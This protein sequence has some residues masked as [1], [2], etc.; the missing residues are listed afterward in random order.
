MT[1]F[2][3][4]ASESVQ[5]TLWQIVDEPTPPLAPVKANTWPTGSAAR[6][7]VEPGQAFHQIECGDRCHEILGHTALQQLAIQENV[8]DHSDD[9]D[10]GP[11]IAGLRQLVELA[12]QL[13]LRKT[14]FHHDEIGASG[15]P[16]SAPRQHWR[17]PS[18]R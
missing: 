15:S 6:I 10:L 12:E 2:E 3:A 4:S 9:D 18:E 13:G 11:L 7:V 17:H 1:T 8:V 16:H 14:R 5:A